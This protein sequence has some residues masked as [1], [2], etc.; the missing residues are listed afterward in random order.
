MSQTKVPA[1]E[2]RMHLWLGAM[3]LGE[4]IKTLER[5]KNVICVKCNKIFFDKETEAE[6]QSFRCVTT[7]E[8]HNCVAVDN[9]IVLWR[10]F[11]GLHWVTCYPDYISSEEAVIAFFRNMN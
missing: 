9:Y 11:R 1:W 8:T 7:R 4:K 6:R 3:T 10:G 2:K 5:G